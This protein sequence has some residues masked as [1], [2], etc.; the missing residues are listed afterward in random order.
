MDQTYKRYLVFWFSQALSQLGSAMTAFALILW[1]YT[2]NGS[3]MTVSLMSFFYYMPYILVSVFAGAFVDRHSKKKIMLVSDSIA[4]LCS[5]VIFM[6]NA[7]N[8]LEIWNIYLVNAVIGLMNAFQGPASQVATGKIVPKEKLE[9]VSGLNS[10]SGNLVSVLSPV[11]SASLFGACG[12]RGILAFD[13]FSFVFAFGVLL[14]VLRIPEDTQ[15]EK[16][17]GSVPAGSAE[18]FRYLKRNRGIF[19]IVLTMAV[20]NFFSRLTY[21][22]ILSPMILARSGNDTAAVG[23][24]NAV[25]GIGGVVGGILVKVV[26]A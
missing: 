5:A 11:L 14:F 4:A 17:K 6:L 24:V 3:A 8:H 15:S 20:L 12:L 2:K 22:N 7:G 25:I 23:V 9:Q 21:E 13:L 19:M 16:Q 10:F 1:V 18:G 26:L